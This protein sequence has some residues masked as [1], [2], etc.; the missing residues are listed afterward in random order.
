VA[1]KRKKKACNHQW[2]EHEGELRCDLC[3][4]LATD[5]QRYME[6]MRKTS[7]TL[8]RSSCVQV[9]DVRPLL[10]LAIPYLESG[11]LARIEAMTTD[12]LLTRR[13]E[14]YWR[15]WSSQP[16][17]ILELLLLSFGSSSGET[18]FGNAMEGIA[19]GV[20]LLNTAFRYALKSSGHSL[21]LELFN[22]AGE[23]MHVSCKAG[24][25]VFNSGSKEN[26]E[27]H[28]GTAATTVEER[29][30]NITLY[31]SGT[32]S[33]RTS[34]KDTY[35]MQGAAAWHFLSGNT[36]FSFQLFMALGDYFWPLRD[37]VLCALRGKLQT[38]IADFKEHYTTQSGEPDWK[39]LHDRA[40]ADDGAGAALVKRF[41]GQ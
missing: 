2:A 3:K 12:E 13:V 28:M 11:L 35:V 36:E 5:H 20:A 24:V 9:A 32:S 15:M 26:Q 10:E 27:L 39:K 40:C 1:V 25:Y 34:K 4:K 30:Y 33:G 7:L 6:D 29:V 22:K 17:E 37:T 21:D 31:Y 38:M 14:K 41:Y 23:R 19:K 8:G 16:D 18:R